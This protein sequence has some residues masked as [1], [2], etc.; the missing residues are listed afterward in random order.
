MLIRVFLIAWHFFT[1][2]KSQLEF[3]K[4]EQASE[5]SEFLIFY[6]VGFSYIFQKTLIKL[7]EKVVIGSSLKA[8]KQF[9]SDTETVYTVEMPLG[10]NARKERNVDI[11]C[12]KSIFKICLVE[13]Q[14]TNKRHCLKLGHF[15][16]LEH[17]FDVIPFDHLIG[18]RR[19]ACFFARDTC[20][21]FN[22]KI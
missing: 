17:P 12:P 3:V 22:V 21:H 19:A 11:R 9:N 14:H 13:L 4:V 15:N 8:L 7:S 1:Q 18:I 20:L 5:D 16:E 6:S 2:V 10:I